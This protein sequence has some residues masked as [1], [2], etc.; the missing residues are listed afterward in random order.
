MSNI[1]AKAEND[2]ATLLER[3][4]AAQEALRAAE[5]KRRPLAFDA[6]MGDAAASKSLKSAT[7]E[8]DEAQQVCEDIELAI[9]EAQ[10]RIISAKQVTHGEVAGRIYGQLQISGE[11][12]AQLWANAQRSCEALYAAWD[13]VLASRTEI[14]KLSYE[15]SKLSLDPTKKE[16]QIKQSDSVNSMLGYDAERFTRMMTDLMPR[17]IFL[18]L[19]KGVRGTPIGDIAEQERNFWHHLLDDVTRQAAE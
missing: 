4:S 16:Q 8:R 2:L 3:K 7:R 5:E 12:R 6:A 9:N 1:L 14:N 17:P 19:P 18:N 10:A 11:H 13:A 15:L